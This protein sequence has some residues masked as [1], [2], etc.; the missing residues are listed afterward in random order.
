MNFGASLPILNYEVKL[1]AVA[2]QKDLK[3]P[4]WCGSVD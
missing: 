4:G 1:P 2:M 3:S